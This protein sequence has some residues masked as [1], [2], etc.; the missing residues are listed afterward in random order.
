MV[1]MCNCDQQALPFPHPFSFTPDLVFNNTRNEMKK[2][3]T[4]FVRLCYIIVS[5]TLLHDNIKKEKKL[6]NTIN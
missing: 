1:E 3:S 2:M 5:Y 4:I 6:N